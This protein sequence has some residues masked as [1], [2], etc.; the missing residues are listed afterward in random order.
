MQRPSSH[1]KWMFSFVI[2]LLAVGIATPVL[3]DYLGPNRTVTTTSSACKAVLYECKQV[4]G[5]WKYKRM[6]DWSCPSGGD[7]C[8]G[9]DDTSGPCD[10]D[11]YVSGHAYCS[12]EQSTVTTTL[13]HPPATISGAVENCTV[14]NGW[15]ITP[16]E[17]SLSAGEPLAGY[18]ILLI[19]GTRNGQT[20]AC[21]NGAASCHVPLSEG[22]NNFNYWALSSWGDSSGMGLSAARVDTVSP[23]VGAD[24]VGVNGAN[25]WYVSP[26]TVSATGSDATSGVASTLL[27]LDPLTNPVIWQPFMTLNEGVHTVTVK[28]TDHAGNESQSSPVFSVDTTTP[29]ISM[30]VSGTVGDNGWYRSVIQVSALPSDATSGIATFEVSSDGAAYQGYTAPI[31]F[32]DGSHTIRFKATDNA[33]NLTETPVQE[34]F[35]DTLPPIVD[36]PPAWELGR[37]VSYDV[38]DAGSGLAALRIVIEDEDE[39]YAKVAWNE[40]VSGSRFDQDIDWDGQFKDKTVAP[41]GTYLVWLKASDQAG[42]ER[43]QLGKV[44]VPEPAGLFNLLP[45]EEVSGETP[46][47]P[48]ELFEAEEVSGITAL[49]S[50][51]FGGATTETTEPTAHSLLLARG[52]ATGTATASP[53]STVLWGAAAAAVIGAATAYALDVTRKRKEAEAEQAL[54]AAQAEERSARRRAKKQQK[55]YENW[56]QQQAQTEYPTNRAIETKIARMEMEEGTE[57]LALQEQQT[58]KSASGPDMPDRVSGEA[59][60]AFLHSTPGAQA[61]ISTNVQQLQQSY[62]EQKA[63]AAEIIQKRVEE[64]AKRAE[65]LHTDLAD[66]YHSEKQGETEVLTPDLSAMKLGGSQVIAALALDDPEPGFWGRLWNGVTSACRDMFGS[67]SSAPTSAPV[68]PDEEAVSRAYQTLVAQMTQTAQAMPTPT[69]TAIS[70]PTPTLPPSPTRVPLVVLADGLNLRYEPSLLSASVLDGSIPKGARVY[71]DPSYGS[72]I[73]DD[74]CWVRVIYTDPSINAKAVA[75]SPQFLNP[76]VDFK[77][78]TAQGALIDYS[79]FVPGW[80]GRH[81]GEDYV[82]LPGGNPNPLIRASVQGVITS[83]GVQYKDGKITGYGNYVIIEYPAASLPNSIQNLPDYKLGNSLY[84]IYAHMLENMSDDLRPGDPVSGGTELGQMGKSGNAGDLVHLHLE[85]RVGEPNQTLNASNGDW[86]RPDKVLPIDPALIFTSTDTSSG[87][88]AQSQ[89]DSNGQPMGEPY[90]GSNP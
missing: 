2:L 30:A 1:Q 73:R 87:W 13:T 78:Q 7:A 48:E 70:T 22:D 79:N 25:G 43:F 56:L 21:P 4:N 32:S 76:L 65:E 12:K 53:S 80:E 20:F 36:L 50:P 54:E 34:F 49:P 67:G 69:P 85:L 26:T 33:G 31:S 40:R 86:Y 77:R 83:S 58:Q 68:Q 28:V 57:W 47:P 60:Q 59:Q 5:H 6:E 81:I 23:E 52:T 27:T 45:K 74:H 61:W 19:E 89:C 17:L 75:A 8:Q 46:L 18:S 72:V 38:Q 29:S 3:A 42:N 55:Q 9:Y 90:L 71:I 63:V 39:R 37:N 64:E 62:V 35:V 66:Y 84:A 10:D 88:A 82:P 15:C 14:R 24:I 44:S 41:P 11:G 51:S 16:P